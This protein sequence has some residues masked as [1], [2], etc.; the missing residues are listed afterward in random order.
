RSRRRARPGTRREPR[1]A[2]GWTFRGPL[3]G[4]RPW[5]GSVVLGPRLQPGHHAAQVGAHRLQ[6]VLGVLLPHAQ[7][8]GASLLVLVD[9]PLREAAVLYLA[10]DLLH[11]LL[12]LG[13]DDPW[14]GH[15]VPVL[16]G[17]RDRVAHEAEAAA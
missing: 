7:E 1:L 17:V 11:R 6:L 12:D 10:Q 9:P 13:V 5:R 16:G 15:V 14:A 3:R 8:V 2:R 4:G